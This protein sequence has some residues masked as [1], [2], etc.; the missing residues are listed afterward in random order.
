MSKSRT[1]I[2]KEKC[3]FATCFLRVTPSEQIPCPH[4]HKAK[5]CS[6]KCLELDWYAIFIIAL[7]AYFFNF[8]LQNTYF[9]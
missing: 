7:F 8:S 4:C 5:Y 3:S 6:H 1:Q 9:S 2:F